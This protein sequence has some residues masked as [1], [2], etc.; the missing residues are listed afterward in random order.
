MLYVYV[1]QCICVCMCVRRVAE[2]GVA[3]QWSFQH[4]TRRRSNRRENLRRD[5]DVPGER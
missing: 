3:T 2:A 4:R 5:H 1:S